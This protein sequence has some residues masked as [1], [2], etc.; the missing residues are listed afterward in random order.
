MSELQLAQSFG[1]FVFLGIYAVEIWGF[2][3]VLR[4]FIAPVIR[5][6][7]GLWNSF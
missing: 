1:F 4:R 3:W 7:F 2:F 5:R 6:I